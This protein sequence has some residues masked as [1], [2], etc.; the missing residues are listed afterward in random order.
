M[1][2]QEW[3]ELTKKSKIILDGA[4][5]SNLQ[6]RGM[7]AGVCPEEWI[8]GHADILCDLQREY[9]Q[10]GTNILYAPTFSGNRIKLE[11][12]GL[13]DRIGQMNHDL[14]SISK[15][16]IQKED[17][18]GKVFVAGD[19]TM[20]GKQVEPVGP[21]PFEDL[22]DIYKEQI[23]Y[24][25]DAGVDLLVVETM[26]SLQECRAAVI[27]AKETTD[28]PVMVTLTFN[29]D[30]RTLFGT[31]PAT[32]S[33]VLTAL[34]VDAV[35]VN[36]STGP[37]KMVSVVQKM[38]EY[39]GL[40]LI[41]KPN[42]GLPQL[43]D[44][45]TVYNMGPEEFAENMMPLV[46][47]GADILGGCCGTTPEHIAKMTELLREN[48]SLYETSCYTRKAVRRALSSERF[49][50]DIDLDGS[51]L[52]IGE[53]INPTGKKGLQAELRD[54][55][56]DLV[57]EM[58]EAQEEAGASI[59]DVNM[60]MNGIDEKEMMLKAVKELSIVTDLPL[61]IDSSHVDVVEAALR[62][63]PGRA[64][65]NSVSLEPEKFEKLIPAAKK[66]GAMFILLPL[67][68]KGLPKNIQEKKDIIHTI[69]DAALEE[70]LSR[71]DIV[72]DGLAATVGA[73]KMAAIEIMETI[74]YCKNEL[75]LA[76]VC[77]L[78]NISFGLP[79]RMYVNSAFMAMAVQSGLTMA[80][81]NPSQDL[82]MHTMF[83]A[84]LLMNKPEG[85]IRYISRVADKKLSVI[86]GEVSPA[87][88][89]SSRPAGTGTQADTA[90]NQDA[91]FQAVVKGRKEKVLELVKERMGE[92]AEAQKIID[93][94]LIPAINHVG[95]LF[96]KQIYY[97]P[98]L[99]ASAEAMEGG[100]GIL[101]PVLEQNS[102]GQSLGTIV[103]ATV[104]HDIH[105]IGKN[106]VALMLKNYG[107][108]VID[109]GKDVPA[110][111]IVAKAKEV[112][113]DIIGLSALMTT[114]MM[115][116]KKVIALAKEEKVRAKIIIGGAVIT[117]GFADEIG[118]DGYSK[119]AQEAVVLVGRLLERV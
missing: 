113:A 116:M 97:L 22:I 80:I 40:P 102:S 86:S 60:G 107:Y 98:Q 6:K 23:G 21:L 78:S 108:N 48:G 25:A 8:L 95:E 7:P 56:L 12:Y 63:Y 115:E 16:A 84:D 69:V 106:L 53:R 88:V 35:G 103:I 59:L 28:L 65:I 17:A 54:G 1:T 58:A 96:D 44:G 41:A 57:S 76:T 85:D 87:A 9:I 74:S 64:L 117:Q 90:D 83:A 37:D 99:I 52:V 94:S 26:M 39:T 14:V 82:L 100:I 46:R 67:S 27:A 51:F 81:A 11:E 68:E 71:D 36:C 5:G 20:T 42:A 29:E 112:D 114:T 2:K 119:D 73:N 93:E 109:L 66:Y 91:L 101:E 111:T 10:A 4:T 18:V 62:I 45:E 92:G 34:G 43:E 24:L 33:L 75:G 30:G 19:L 118:A 70:G 55:C 49:T 72:V 47:E 104:E 38:R 61:S 31:D 110:E 3:K 13:S 77:G 79:E 89:V 15:D 105:D 50:K 32:A